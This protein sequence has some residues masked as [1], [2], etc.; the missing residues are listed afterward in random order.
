MANELT[1]VSSLVFDDGAA[2]VQRFGGNTIV[3]S[4]GNKLIIHQIVT[5]G[6]TEAVLDKGSVSTLGWVFFKNLDG[7]NFITLRNGSG[8]GNSFAR[9]VAGMEWQYYSG[10]TTAPWAIA[11]TGSCKLEYIFCAL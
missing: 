9:L 4:M 6:I 5:V 1:A 8:A 3:T 2:A 10:V 11:D 7:T